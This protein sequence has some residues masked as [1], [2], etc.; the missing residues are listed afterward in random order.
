MRMTYTLLLVLLI[1]LIHD[2]VRTRF[3]LNSVR[4]RGH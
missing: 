4:S 1:S 3:L 2:Y